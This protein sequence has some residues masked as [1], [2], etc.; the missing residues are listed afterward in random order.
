[1]KNFSIY[2]LIA[3]I[4]L[5]SSNLV[6]AQN[7]MNIPEA[8]NSRIFST[9]GAQPLDSLERSNYTNRAIM[10]IENKNKNINK[11]SDRNEVQIYNSTDNSAPQ[12]GLFKGFRVIW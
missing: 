1:M 6:L 9:N 3:I 10:Q 2:I 11:S 4:T 12:K 8:V 5:L 7:S